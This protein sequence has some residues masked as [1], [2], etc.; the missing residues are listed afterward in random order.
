MEFTQDQVRRMDII[1]QLYRRGMSVHA[2]QREV[3][4][5][6]NLETYSL[7]SVKSDIKQMLA[8][9]REARINRLDDAVELELARIDEVINE[10]WGAW[11]RS[12]ENSKRTTQRQRA[13]PVGEGVESAD[14][15]AVVSMEQ[16]QSE[17]TQV[18]DPRFLE[19]VNKMGAE[20]R[21]LLGLYK[22]ERVELTGAEG[23]PI[24]AEVFHGF[25]FIPW[26]G[27]LNNSEQTKIASGEVVEELPPAE[28]EPVYAEIIDYGSKN[29]REAEGSL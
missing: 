9:W 22:P 7:A 3:M 4:T 29:K 12:K 27:G 15:V 2:I 20:R 26:T 11:E 28:P 1:S 24:K 5:R 8:E 25:Q 21:K 6:L 19:I 18:G 14:G 10:A 16:E 17:E 23:E 13:A